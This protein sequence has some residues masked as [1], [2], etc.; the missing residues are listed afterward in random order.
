MLVTVCSFHATALTLEVIFVSCLFVRTEREH[1][2]AHRVPRWAEWSGEGA[3]H[4]WCKR[5][6]AISGTTHTYT[7]THPQCKVEWSVRTHADECERKLLHTK[8]PSG[9]V[10]VL[11]QQFCSAAWPIFNT[12]HT[13]LHTHTVDSVTRRP[14]IM[15]ISKPWQKL[16]RV[17]KYNKLL[18][19]CVRLH[20]NSS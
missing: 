10:C 9:A 16:L 4:K 20:W 17:G 19:I 15:S 1:R 3:R 7:H 8:H 14:I 5:Q 13:R 11:C 18:L 12:Q 2:P 6:R